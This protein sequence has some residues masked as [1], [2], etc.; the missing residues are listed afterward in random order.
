LADTIVY[1]PNAWSVVSATA[2]SINWDRSKSTT[3]Q[4]SVT[5]N[6]NAGAT[7][8]CDG[9]G[10]QLEGQDDWSN[11]LYRSSAA[12]N[13]A[14]GREVP[15]EMTSDNEKE[16]FLNKDTDNGVGDGKDCGGT[17]PE[18]PDGTTSF[19]CT[20]RIDIK[21]AFP[22]PKIIDQTGNVTIVIFSEKTG[23]QEWNAPAQVKT[24]ASL[25]FMVES[26]E[27]SVKVNNKGGGTCSVSD[28]ADPDT[29]QKDGIKDLKCQFEFPPDGPPAG[30]H[31][32]IV[33]GF[34]FDPLTGDNRAFSA[35]QEVTIVR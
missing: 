16:F 21:P 23:T 3:P 10:T 19:L 24:D 18:P 30:T 27:V 7:A 35:R 1:G 29:G 5:A 8:G 11:V 31:F 9:T 26:F 12:I 22:L 20:H 6:I 4:P 13:F 14:G 33:S 34:F 25:K 17:I 28:V 15:V 32:G 2:P